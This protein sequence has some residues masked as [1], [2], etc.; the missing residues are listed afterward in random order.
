M[1]NLNISNRLHKVLASPIRKLIPYANEAKRQGIKIYHLNIGD[2]DVKTPEVML[3]V[4]RH[5]EHNPIR[6]AH[7]WGETKF[8][9]AL[10]AYYHK[11]GYK[12]LKI[13]FRPTD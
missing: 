8:L 13:W 10:L 3:D 9:D 4:L 6:Y 1:N 11:L 7:P 2:P 5:W 12:W